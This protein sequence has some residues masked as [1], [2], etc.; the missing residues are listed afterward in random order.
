MSFAPALVVASFSAGCTD[1]DVELVRG[2]SMPGHA[3]TTVGAAFDA[4][5]DDRRW[6]TFKTTK[7]TRVV[8]LEA[9]VGN[10]LHQT[11]AGH[12]RTSIEDAR[13]R[14]GSAFDELLNFFQRAYPAVAQNPDR[15]SALLKRHGCGTVDRVNIPGQS[16][17]MPQC[18]S[19]SGEN[20]MREAVSEWADEHLWPV[21]TPVKA[22]WTISADGRSFELT[23]LESVAW[24]SVA[25]QIVLEL[26]YE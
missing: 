10:D 8:Q 14:N 17:W 11:A 18:G 6:T 20:F 24:Q 4:S 22:Q 25:Q 26:I 13:K 5:F 3:S 9:K 12:V 16:V 15:V 21:G 2:G 19:N 1:Q 23:H 7:G